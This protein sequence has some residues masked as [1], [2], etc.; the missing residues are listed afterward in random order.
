MYNCRKSIDRLLGSTIPLVIIVALHLP[1]ADML[2][3]LESLKGGINFCKNPILEF[4]QDKR[5]NA[6]YAPK[7]SPLKTRYRNKL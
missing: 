6:A 4:R 3:L 2:K 1:L 5:P 7:N